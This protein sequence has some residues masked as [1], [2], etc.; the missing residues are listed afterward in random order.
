MTETIPQTASPQE[1]ARTV[2]CG[3]CW[4]P[5]GTPC[6]ASPAGSHLARYCDAERR[7]VLAREDL[8]A[9]IGQ[10]EVIAGLVIIP[11]VTR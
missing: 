1:T 6:Q 7:G 4:T 10:L 8:A 5:P 3:Y 9:V 2:T 11:D